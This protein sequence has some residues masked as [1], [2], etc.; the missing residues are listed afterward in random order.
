[1]IWLIGFSDYDERQAGSD[2][3]ATK[4]WSNWNKKGDKIP[5]W[6]KVMLIAFII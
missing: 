2:A 6:V 5:M 1:M 4:G 3:L